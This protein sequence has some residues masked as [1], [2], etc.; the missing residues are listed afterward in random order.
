MANGGYTKLHDFLDQKMRMSHIYQ[1]VMLE[2]LLTHGGTASIRD[3][4][5]AILSHDESQIDYYEQIVKNMPG[6]VLTSHG[7]VRRDGLG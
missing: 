3:V 5:E 1:P 4:V 6:R 7:I 2:V